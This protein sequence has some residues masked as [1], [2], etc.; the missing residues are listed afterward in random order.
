MFPRYSLLN[1]FFILFVVAVH[2]RRV[3][4]TLPRALLQH[5]AVQYLSNFEFLDPDKVG[6]GN[7]QQH[8]TFVSLGGD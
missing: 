4:P 8:E 6:C 3:V 7:R 2:Y 1:E 5:V